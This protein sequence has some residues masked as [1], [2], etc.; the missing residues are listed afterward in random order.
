MGPD[1]RIEWSEL[2]GR[3][4]F[5]PRLG[6]EAPSATWTLELLSIGRGTATLEVGDGSR[7]IEVDGRQLTLEHRP[8]LTESVELT[9]QGA[10]HSVVLAEPLAG[11]GDLVA[12]FSLD[13]VGLQRDSNSAD[14]WRAGEFG[15]VTLGEVKGLDSAGREV[16]GSSRFVDG[17]LELRL[18]SDF[19]D[20]AAWPLVLDPLIGS[21][22]SIKT[23]SMQGHSDLAYC[24]TEDEYLAVYRIDY[25][26]GDTDTYAQR[27]DSDG[28][29]VGGPILLD[30]TIMPV[31][32]GARV[33]AD[34][35]LGVYGVVWERF[36]GFSEWLEVTG[37]QASNG[38]VSPSVATLDVGSG[39]AYDADLSGP[40]ADGRWLA[41]F[42]GPTG[43]IFGAL[44]EVAS[45]G[46][47]SVVPVAGAVSFTISGAFQ[48]FRPR[49]SQ[50]ASEESG[51]WLVVWERFFSTPAPGD[52][53]LFARLVTGT[54]TTP[55]SELQIAGAIGPEEIEP[56]VAMIDFDRFALIFAREQPFSPG[57]FDVVGIPL[58]ATVFGTILGT[59][60]VLLGDPNVSEQDPA[61]A[62]NGTSLAV[63]AE[64]GTTG[65]F[66]PPARVYL[67][68]V[69]PLA[70][71]VIDPF[72]AAGSVG[73]LE[74]D[75]ALASRWPSGSSCLTSFTVADLTFPSLDIGL[76]EWRPKTGS[77]TPLL[78]G[79]CGDF[80]TSAYGAYGGNTNFRVALKSD[81][82]TAA[83]LLLIS[84]N[85]LDLP[86]GSCLIVPD[87]T[88]G[89]VLV[90]PPSVF[91][92]STS[93]TLG[94]PAA[95]AGR[96]YFL[97]WLTASTGAAACPELGVTLRTPIEVFVD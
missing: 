61:V 91:G 14:L 40:N 69:D 48:D 83:N 33:S 65:L 9:T 68:G 89:P 37:I 31:T 21:F 11:T 18:P 1:Y 85:R 62:F 43:E 45:S 39:I 74:Y 15:G 19:V 6:R 60:T 66:G 52:H 16:L 12:R 27:L 53:D 75:P 44:V 42:R 92:T 32:T 5:T 50:Q 3:L 70:L 49:V 84:A 26:V 97:Q 87:P 73:S 82:G 4:R 58:S 46:A 57:L 47:A 76:R 88:S 23:D 2:D 81:A 28:G 95:A 56:A 20:A 24:A 22:N 38:A 96:T 59:E 8:G 63:A 72:A 71:S 10:K 7:L 36:D 25:S 90:A 17:Q 41:A 93:L 29:S 51:Y 55:Q 78:D 35:D 13:A 79:A 67:G 86:C 54:G 34:G 77:I 94:I 30:S 64:V 80:A